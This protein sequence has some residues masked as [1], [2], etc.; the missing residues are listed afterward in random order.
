MV[1][2]PPVIGAF[3]FITIASLRVR[4]LT[5]GC[6]PRLDGAHCAA[7]MAQMEVAAGK[8]HAVDEP[9]RAGREA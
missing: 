3:Q 8:V 5:A 6:T 9:L 1:L 7:V 2:R 4:Q